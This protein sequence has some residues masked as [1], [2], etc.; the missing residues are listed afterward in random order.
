M[1]H[2]VTIKSK[3]ALIYL[4]EDYLEALRRSGYLVRYIAGADFAASAADADGIIHIFSVYDEGSGRRGKI[5]RRLNINAPAVW[6][7]TKHGIIRHRVTIEEVVATMEKAG[8]A[9]PWDKIDPE[10]L[11][12]WR[13]ARQQGA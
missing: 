13:S 12:E 2:R 3:Y 7:D 5:K 1:D 10:F 11:R 9:V 8:V 6:M 4:W